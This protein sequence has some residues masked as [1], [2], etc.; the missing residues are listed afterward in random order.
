MECLCVRINL[1]SQGAV[2]ELYFYLFPTCLFGITIVFLFLLLGF[3][4][5]MCVFC[6]WMKMSSVWGTAPTRSCWLSPYWI[7]LWKFSMLTHSRY[8]TKWA[9]RLCRVWCSCSLIGNTYCGTL[10]RDHASHFR[11][12]F[13][14]K[15]VRTM[16]GQHW[17]EDSFS[18][19][20]YCEPACA[21]FTLNPEGMV[22]LQSC[23]AL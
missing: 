8:M 5:N 7:A 4:W 3:L 12:L 9:V 20:K 18:P 23:K 10:V 22:V 21:R 2:W 14:S 13:A 16:T 11:C 15:P 17:G 19:G 1:L 6:S